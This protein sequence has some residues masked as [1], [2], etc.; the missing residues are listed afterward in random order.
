M[1]KFLAGRKRSRNALLII[2]VGVLT[3]SLIGLFSVVV[4]GG[5]SGL[6]GGT[7][8]DDAVVAKVAGLDITAKELKDELSGFSRRISQGQGRVGGGDS[9]ATTYALYGKQVLDNLIRSKLMIYEAD[10][11]NLGAS[12]SEV[13]SRLRQIFSPWPG[14]ERYRLQ[15][16]QAGL[17]PM[18]FEDSLRSSLAQEHLRSYVTAAVQ[19]SESDIEDDY[20]HTNTQYTVRWATVSPEAQRDKVQVNDPDLQAYFAAHKDDFKITAEERKARYVFIDQTKAGETIQPTDDE[21]R[22]SFNPENYITQVRVSQIVLNVPKQ[23]ASK[24]VETGAPKS[25]ESDQPTEETI[26]EEAQGLVKRAQGADGKPAEDFAALAKENSDDPSKSNGGDIGWVNKSDKRSTDDPLNRVFTMKQGEVSQPIKKGDKYYILKVTDRK[27]PTFAERRDQILKDERARKS[28]SRAVEIAIEAEAKFKES[29]N[30]DAVVSEINAKYKAPI[31]SVRETPFFAQGDKLP[32]LGTAPDFESAVF[33]LQNLNDVADRQNVD[34]GLAIAQFLEKRDPH[35]PTFEEVKAKV[36]ERYRTDKAKEMAEQKAKQIAEGKTPD[37]L[38]RIA[39]SLGIKVEDRAGLPETDS[40][41]PL[42]NE[43]DR[44]AV[45][46]LN[47]GEVTHSPIKPES[48]DSYVVVGLVARKDADMGDA[49]KK[50]KS[51]IEQR[52]LDDRRNVYFQTYLSETQRLM[53]EAGKIKVY[54]D[55]IT[56]VLEAGG[57]PKDAGGAPTSVPRR[58][59]RPPAPSGR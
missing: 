19:V 31:A 18:T 46:K 48:S 5:A 40:I 15:L 58:T 42:V 34:K 7:A 22:Q 10:Q 35:D 9:I 38:K 2:F 57:P 32:I 39:D 6:F 55:V 29:K 16:Q 3:L 44:A 8:G 23:D 47:V 24:K 28:Y 14:A 20:K 51:S 52:L 1:L 49:F 53:S 43:G 11:L 30:A 54:D 12:D 41:G 4:S 26:R 36:E 59:R 17:S 50:E 37:D 33:G 56:E 45:Y 21:L 25:S 13:Q 27:V